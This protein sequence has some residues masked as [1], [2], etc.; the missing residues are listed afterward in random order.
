MNLNNDIVQA[1]DK[2]LPNALGEQ[3]RKR[4]EQLESLE[5]QVNTLDAQ[6][7]EAHRRLAEH[8][9]IDSKQRALMERTS[10]LDTREA[11]LRAKELDHALSAERV[12]SANERASVAFELARIMFGNKRV[13]RET[14]QEDEN[15]EVPMPSGAYTHTTSDSRRTTREVETEGD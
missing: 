2:H 14:V 9:D 8:A 7:K 5:R 6:T 12:K 15:R 13:W 1:I 4:L 3:L 11:A 10:A